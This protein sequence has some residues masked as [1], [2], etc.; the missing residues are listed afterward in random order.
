MSIQTTY[1]RPEDDPAN[2]FTGTEVVGP[3]IVT[4]VMGGIWRLYDHVPPTVA[5]VRGILEFSESAALHKF[6]V[7]D[8]HCLRLVPGS[9]KGLIS[10]YRLLPRT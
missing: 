10:G 1:L 7:K 2:W 4:A 9:L 8:G 3:A 5:L 6:F